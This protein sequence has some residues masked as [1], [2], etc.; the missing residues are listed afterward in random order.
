[1]AQSTPGQR[2]TGFNW[3][4]GGFIIGYHVALL[5]GLPFYFYYSPPGAAL[6][7]T[8][9]VLLVLTEIGIGAAYHRFYAHRCYT[10]SKP[11][12]AVLLFLATLATQGSALQ[13]S[14]DHR[15]HHSFSDSD[16]DPYSIK[17]GFWHA[18]MLWLFE[19][20]KPIDDKRV[21]DLR[22][23]PLVRFQHRWA[24]TLSMTSNL[25]VFLLV[26]WIVGDYLGAFVL[27][28]WTRLLVSHHLT[29]F[30]NSLCHCWGEQTY[31]REH[32]AVDN[33]VLAILT[34]GEGY[35]NFHHTFPND[36]RNGVRWYHIDPTKWTIWILSKLGLARDLRRVNPLRIRR[37]LLAEDRK[38]LLERLQQQ[39]R[40][41]RAE[42]EQRIE[43]LAESI[44]S[45][46]GHQGTLVE[47]IR[48]L[49]RL[50]ID[51]RTRRATSRRMR[52]E[53]RALRHSLRRD[54]RAWN[55]LCNAV[56]Q[57]Q[58]AF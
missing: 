16:D 18:H 24:G 28:W 30:V 12:E 50:G 44:Q 45:K 42:L 19:K 26:G 25:L 49:E 35:H 10:L 34:V 46:L 53:L 11:V 47:R 20:S 41:G 54:W 32:S 55:R 33:Y 43:R 7:L 37:R 13:W 38:L 3:T 17:K 15:L 58:P 1:V 39:V 57:L 36:Y 6:V 31:S 48:S 40:A 5:I 23:N 22:A 52:A 27:T 8:T 14:Y 51:R 29:W 9:V 56:L 2:P 4:T 21:P